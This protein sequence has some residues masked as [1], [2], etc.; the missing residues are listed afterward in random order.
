MTAFGVCYIV[1]GEKNTEDGLQLRSRKLVIKSSN[2]D[3]NWTKEDTLNATRHENDSTVE[4]DNLSNSTGML[5]KTNA[6]DPNVI[7][8]TLIAQNNMLMELLKMRTNDKP[9]NDITIAPD[10]NKS[11]PIF[12]G[13]ETDFQALDWLRTVNSVAN[14]YRWPDNFKLQSVRSNLEGPARHWFASR[15]IN[16]WSDFETQFRKTFVGVVMTGDRWKDMARRVQSRNENVREYFHEKV[17][18]CKLVGMSF[19]ETKIQILEGLFSKELSV[20]LLS[21]NHMDADE[22]LADTVDYERLDASQ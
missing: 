18:L 15:D 14:L 9:P 13:L 17:H 1:M 3:D 10:L 22:L 6:S 19:H 2:D 5:K 7:M 12:N 20:Y 16:T 4:S 21:R 8:N 11:V